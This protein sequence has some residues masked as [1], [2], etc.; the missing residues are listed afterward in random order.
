[1]MSASTLCVRNAA[2]TVAGS[3][4]LA[5]IVM[6]FSPQPCFLANCSA[7]QKVNEPLL[8]T[9]I[10]LPLRSARVLA[11]ESAGTATPRKVAGPT[12]LA[13]AISG[14]PLAIKASSGP[15]PTP[16][17]IA[18]AAAAWCILPPPL[19][20]WIV[21]SRP[22]LA[23]MPVL[24]PTST[25]SIGEEVGEALPT[26]NLSAACAPLVLSKAIAASITVPTINR[27]MSLI[28]P[29]GVSSIRSHHDTSARLPWPGRRCVASIGGNFGGRYGRFRR[30]P[31]YH[32][33]SEHED[34]RRRRRQ[35]ERDRLQDQ[36]R[37]GRCQRSA[38]RVPDDG[39]CAFLLRTH[40]DQESDHFRLAAFAHRLCAGSECAQ[41]AD[42]HGWGFHQRAG[43][44]SDHC[45]RAGDRRRCR[46][47]R[48]DRRGC[49]RC[50]GRASG[51]GF[52]LNAAQPSAAPSIFIS[53]SSSVGY[54]ALVR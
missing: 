11:W 12:T 6:S 18:P 36:P 44:L 17:S 26:V 7:S 21:T 51:C 25:G 29:T 38:D 13:T 3:L 28:S 53:R 19:K 46:G 16:R 34:A 33:R 52:G 31:S 48:E 22:C 50:Q 23:K 41:H 1:M 45:G 42:P 35:G 40:H 49:D 30:D 10:F 43:R 37:R 20:F 4:P 2:T 15:A 39:W 5:T 47:R 14:A 54:R 27:F 32:P 9:A 24:T 8:D